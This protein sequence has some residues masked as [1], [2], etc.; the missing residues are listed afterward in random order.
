MQNFKVVKT[1]FSFK[2]TGHKFK[3]IFYGASSVKYIDLSYIP[4]NHMNL[5]NFDDMVVRKFQI[6]F[7]VGNLSIEIV[8]V[9]I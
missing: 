8:I 2:E 1:D 5:I 7:L 4:R 6:E 9:F 3:L